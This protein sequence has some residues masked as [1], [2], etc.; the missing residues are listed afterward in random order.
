[1]YWIFTVFFTEKNI[2]EFL[3]YYRLTFPES[4]I[5]PKLH[6]FEEHVIP[7]ITQWRVGLGIMGEQG[8]ESI[9]ARFN[10][11]ERT[12]SNMTNPVQ[13][14]KCMVMEHLRQTCPDNIVKEPPPQK[15]AKISTHTNTWEQVYCLLIAITVHFNS[16]LL[17]F[18]RYF[19]VEKVHV[20]ACVFTFR[21]M[22]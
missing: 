16:Y 20:Y 1:M 14:L 6:I 15:R 12:Y 17:L 18:S 2:S 9:H 4:S 10:T 22:Q 5:S 13:R 11:L 19:L 21:C 3:H 7:F 8:A